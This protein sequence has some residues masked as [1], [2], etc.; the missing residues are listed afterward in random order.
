VK[1]FQRVS[2]KE[3]QTKEQT[4]GTPVSTEGLTGNLKTIFVDEPVPP[5]APFCELSDE[6][7]LFL[8]NSI[9]GYYSE[10]LDRFTAFE[11]YGKLSGRIDL[12]TSFDIGIT[13]LHVVGTEE[14][15]SAIVGGRY[16]VFHHNNAHMA[17]RPAQVKIES[18]LLSRKGKIVVRS[19]VFKRGGQ[20][21]YYGNV[22][23]RFAD[24]EKMMQ[25][26]KGDEGWRICFFLICAL[27]DA[28]KSYNDTL[29]KRIK[30]VDESNQ[31]AWKRFNRVPLG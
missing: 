15:Q 16:I 30:A 12:G 2:P 11:K 20:D 3:D 1:I 22:T 18:L 25:M 28:C 8:L 27:Q 5:R 10:H 31:E 24:D 4:M 14:E 9:I 13:G 17:S 21:S 7:R 19:G 29:T 6:E 26:L 23:I